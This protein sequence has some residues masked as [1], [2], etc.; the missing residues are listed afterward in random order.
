[1]TINIV[2][3]DVKLSSDFKKSIE[4]GIGSL[5]KRF[6]GNPFCQIR[7]R[8]VEN[9]LIKVSVLIHAGKYVFKGEDIAKDKFLALSHSL[10]DIEKSLNKAKTKQLM[11]RYMPEEIRETI[12]DENSGEDEV[13]DI[14]DFITTKKEIKVVPMTI[15]EAYMQMEL[16]GHTFFAFTNSETGLINIL[17]RKRS[18]E[19]AYGI[20]QLTR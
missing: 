6:K 5:D 16:L 15:D 4:D 20:I 3:K 19:E 18:S 8:T 13:S 9:N 14:T 11:K 12:L 17:Y 2:S 1:M 7:V 10:K